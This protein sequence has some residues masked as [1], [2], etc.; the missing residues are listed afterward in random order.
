MIARSRPAVEINTHAVLLVAFI[1]PIGHQF[2][3]ILS[4]VPIFELT[5]IGHSML[6]IIYVVSNVTHGG[7]SFG[8][9]GNA[10]QISFSHTK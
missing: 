6:L 10:L 7:E 9:I 5:Q 8:S 4:V 2:F 1:S 3:H